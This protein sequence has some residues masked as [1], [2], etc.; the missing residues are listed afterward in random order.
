MLNLNYEHEI[1]TVLNLFR[2]YLIIKKISVVNR[3]INKKRTT[4]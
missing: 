2:A 1:V 3:L 4:K